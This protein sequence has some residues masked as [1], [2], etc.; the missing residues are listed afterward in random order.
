MTIAAPAWMH[1]PAEADLSFVTRPGREFVTQL[2]NPKLHQQL[3]HSWTFHANLRKKRLLKRDANVRVGPGHRVP[4][5][6]Q[7][8]ETMTAENIS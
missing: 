1:Q 3:I 4:R 6:F 5:F 2:L 8:S 7:N